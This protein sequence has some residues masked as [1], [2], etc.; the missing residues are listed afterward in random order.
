MATDELRVAL[1]KRGL[2]TPRERIGKE[3][4]EDEKGKKKRIGLIDHKL[5]LK[6][7][8]K[9]EHSRQEMANRMMKAR[10]KSR[11]RQFREVK[12]CTEISLTKTVGW[13][14]YEYLEMRRN[15]MPQDSCF[16]H[17]NYILDKV[18][19]SFDN[20]SAQQVESMIKGYEQIAETLQPKYAR[21]ERELEDHD[22]IVVQLRRQTIQLPKSGMFHFY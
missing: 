12:G 9:D 8:I 20:S 19:E 4:E 5:T 18:S 22:N 17:A 6:N 3:D 11:I 1:K 2:K 7:W 16:Q 10:I 21:Y 15:S 14:P 13:N